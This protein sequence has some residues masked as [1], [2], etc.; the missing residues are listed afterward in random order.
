[1]LPTSA[2]EFDLPQRLIATR[3]AEPR[4]SARLFVISRSD[5]ERRE[6]ALV[7]DLPEILGRASDQFTMV[8]NVSGV[9]RARLRGV[10]SDTGGG[11]T[12]LFLE[13]LRTE[14]D[15]R[16][17][18]VMLKSG[19]RLA[20]G[21]TIELHPHVSPGTSK[22]ES[23]H[24]GSAL[25]LELL[26]RETDAWLTKVRTPQSDAAVDDDLSSLLERIGATPLPPYILSA[27]RQAGE[28]PAD[29]QDRAWYQ[30]VY[31]DSAHAASVAAPTAGLHFTHE[32]LD[33]L[34]MQGVRR[35]DVALHVGRGTFK[36][37]ESA[38]IEEHPM[39]AE[40]YDIPP[41]TMGALSERAA[42]STRILCVGTTSARAL[43]SVPTRIPDEPLERG[44][45]GEARILITPGHQW[46]H[47]D[48]L[49]TNFHLPRSTLL[50]MVGALLPEGVERL[51]EHYREAI[52][53]EYRFFSYGDAMLVLP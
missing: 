25:T 43:E 47:V 44:L 20:P 50:A 36:P 12:G 45:T 48:A 49:L 15:G 35:R 21:R 8:C 17:W 53:M 13:E 3:P 26:S 9:L 11:V 6:H 28:S 18:R 32:L 33:R 23:K 31:A 2:L 38:H 24:E 42:G 51:L 34:A 16:L 29:A 52:S 4:D 10:R 1:M 46:R 40:R 39:H 19:G 30:T 7:R 22:H 5:P 41:E 27:R 14:R 37:V